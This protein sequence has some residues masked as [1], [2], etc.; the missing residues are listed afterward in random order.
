[1]GVFILPLLRKNGNGEA[2]FTTVPQ[3]EKRMVCPH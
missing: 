3:R 1:M 2:Q